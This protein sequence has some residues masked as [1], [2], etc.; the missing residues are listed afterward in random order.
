MLDGH[1]SIDQKYGLLFHRNSSSSTCLF[2]SQ[3][4]LFLFCE[5]QPDCV[6][7]SP[8]DLSLWSSDSLPGV[9]S[10]LSLCFKTMTVDNLSVCLSPTIVFLIYDCPSVHVSISY[11]PLY[12]SPMLVYLSVRPSVCPPVCPS[13]RLS[14]TMFLLYDCP[15]I[16]LPPCLSIWP[17]VCPS[18][19]HR[20]PPLWL[21]VCPSVP[22]SVCLSVC[23]PPCSSS[24][25]ARSSLVVEL[26]SD[27]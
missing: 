9:V 4:A 5:T 18:V 2:I 23:H 14:P 1:Y 17:P 26:E 8:R 15:S 21:S 16:R 10:H 3:L 27:T 12:S 24:I 19:T 20:A 13:A 25:T 22:L 6:S 7:P 11:Q